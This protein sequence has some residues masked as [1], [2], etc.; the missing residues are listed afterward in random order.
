M[1]QLENIL[2]N[3][4]AANIRNYRF[5][6]KDSYSQWSTSYLNISKI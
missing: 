3:I 5:R 4:L 6:N 2:K 1:Q